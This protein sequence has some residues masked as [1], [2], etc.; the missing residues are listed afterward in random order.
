MLK[1]NR[2]IDVYKEIVLKVYTQ[3]GSLFQTHQ[4]R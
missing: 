2:R 3:P 1:K 4:K